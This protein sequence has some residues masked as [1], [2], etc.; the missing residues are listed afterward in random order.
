MEDRVLDGA[1]FFAHAKASLALF[2]QSSC[3]PFQLGEDEA[4]D[5][6]KASTQDMQD[7]QKQTKREEAVSGYGFPATDRASQLPFDYKNYVIP[8]YQKPSLPSQPTHYPLRFGLRM[9]RLLP[10][11]QKAKA[12]MQ[13]VPSDLDA[14]TVFASSTFADLWSDAQMEDCIRYVRGNRSLAIPEEWR[15]MLPDA[16]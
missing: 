6:G 9:L 3:W 14:K 5:S 16:L 1:L 4:Q 8:D 7:Y 10:Q 13:P 12:S 15:A 2:Q 11:L